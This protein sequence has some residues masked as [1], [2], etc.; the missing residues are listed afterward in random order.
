MTIGHNISKQQVFL[1]GMLHHPHMLD[2]LRSQ[3]PTLE[4]VH[5]VSP[6]DKAMQEAVKA[7]EEC[8]LPANRFKINP[9]D[10]DF[11]LFTKEID[12]PKSSPY[13]P[14]RSTSPLKHWRKRRKVQRAACS[15]EE[16]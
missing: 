7:A 12:C 3:N 4:I 13:H 11:A 8:R 9:S 10:Y 2:V 6:E 15:E 16:E 1:V 14:C 5:V